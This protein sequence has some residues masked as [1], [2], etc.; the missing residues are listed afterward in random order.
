MIRRRRQRDALLV[1][2]DAA[3]PS[4]RCRNCSSG[5][6]MPIMTMFDEHARAVCGR[7][8]PFAVAVARHQ[9]WPTISAAQ[10]LRTSGCVPVWQKLQVSVQPTWVETQNA[11]RSSSGMLT[12]LGLVAVGEAQQPLARAVDRALLGD[13]LGPLDHEQLGQTIARLLGDVGH[14]PEVAHAVPVDPLPDLARAE[15]FQPGLGQRAPS[16]PRA[17]G[18]PGCGACRCGRGTAR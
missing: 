3:A 15:R 10:R 8:R 1:H 2:G 9:N 11:P 7:R 16:A 12:R 13:D 18:R 6:P 17:T 4:P 14:Q 5:S